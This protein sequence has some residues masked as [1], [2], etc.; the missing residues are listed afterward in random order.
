MTGPYPS[1][2]AFGG[3]GTIGVA[4]A[5]EVTVVEVTVVV[6]AVGR[7]GGVVV[8]VGLVATFWMALAICLATLALVAGVLST[9]TRRLLMSIGGT[10]NRLWSAESTPLASASISTSSSMSTSTTL[11][12]V[13]GFDLR[14][15]R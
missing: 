7:L 5:V 12:T 8:D 6:V 11:A 15:T 2:G 3:G 4:S 10:I 13:S 14:Y 9:W 1:F